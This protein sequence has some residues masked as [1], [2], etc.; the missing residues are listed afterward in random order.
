MTERARGWP[1]LLGP[2]VYGVAAPAS[3]VAVA[4]AVIH[5]RPGTFRSTMRLAIISR[6]RSGDS[7]VRS[8][9]AD[10]YGLSQ[11]AVHDPADLPAKPPDRVVVQL[12]WYREPFLQAR[13]HRHEFQVLVLAR[14]PLD[15]LISIL[16]SVRKEPENARWLE[17]NAEL[18]A[19][20]G[21]ACPTDPA[22]ESYAVSWGAENILSISYGWWHHPNVI[23]LRCEEL[24]RNPMT[25]FGQLI[26]VLGSA[27][28]PLDDVLPRSCL[29]AW[30]A[31]AGVGATLSGGSWDAGGGVSA[32]FGKPDFQDSA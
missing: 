7:W 6:P 25:S 8:V 22:F 21:H 26:A 4:L 10:L 31:T 13:L 3:W 18:P 20:L 2:L 9:L 28:R 29:A 30:Q 19:D 1:N 16:H 32:L 27:R 15:I 5:C 24:V 17:G 11:I 14:D 23:K 12:H